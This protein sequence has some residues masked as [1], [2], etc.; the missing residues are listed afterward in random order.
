MG[1]ISD[2]YLK[3]NLEKRNSLH[4]NYVANIL[5]MHP[6]NICILPLG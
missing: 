1:G 6:F 4:Y 5:C 3:M 2:Y